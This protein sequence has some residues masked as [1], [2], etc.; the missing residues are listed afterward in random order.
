MTPGSGSSTQG[1]LSAPC[2]SQMRCSA[3]STLLPVPRPRDTKRGQ[4]PSTV[5]ACAG[6][7]CASWLRHQVCVRRLQTWRS[8]CVCCAQ[9]HA[10]CTRI[11]S[12]LGVPRA[13]VAAPPQVLC[14]M[15]NAAVVVGVVDDNGVHEELHLPQCI[16]QPGRTGCTAP[17][18]V[19]KFVTAHCSM[20]ALSAVNCHSLLAAALLSCFC[21]L[22]V[23]CTQV[24]TLQWLVHVAEPAGSA[25]KATATAF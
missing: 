25:H 23:V 17:T 5:C 24:A 19:V 1:L 8:R 9:H 6:V 15:L 21:V 11:I 13:R 12:S 20:P 18:L 10:I 4:S 7:G 3:T 14:G 22:L 2:C 16:D